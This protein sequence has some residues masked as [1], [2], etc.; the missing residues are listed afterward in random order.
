[1]PVENLTNIVIGSGEGG[2]YLAWH[3]AQSGQ[4]TAVIERRW[5]G[6]SCPNINCLPSKNEIWSAKVANLV[7]H[8]AKF[9]SVTAPG[10]VDMAVVRG[11]K[12]KMVEGLVA[13]H[14][15]R[16]KATGAELIM[17]EAKFAGTNT[18]EVT[19]NGG[20]SRTLRGERIFLNLGTHASI[21]SAP[22]LAACA[23]LTHIEVL[24]LDRLPDHLIVIGGGYVGLEFAQ[25]YRRF[26]SQV[27]VLQHGSQLLAK[28]DPDLAAEILKVFN[29]E[30]IEVLAP[31]K[32]M[33]VEGR[34]GSGVTIK[35][36]TSSGETQISGSDILVATGR[37][38]NTAEIGLDTAGVQVDPRGYI[39]VND[40]L[41]TT[42]TNV[43]AIGECAGSP[44]FTHASLD[45]FRVIRD[46]L[47]GGSRSTRNRVVPSCLFTDPQVAQIG[48]TESEARS[49][50]V[51]YQIAKL[52]MV[53]VLRTRTIDETIGFMKALI[54]PN[55]QRILGFTMI[56]P[57]AGEVMAVV[58]MAMQA[59][60]PYMALRDAI[61]THPTMAEGLN[62]LF[63]NVK[64][65]NIDARA[66]TAV[67]RT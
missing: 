66:A 41:E 42:A 8:S 57:E 31:A 47:A 61:L 39:K 53:A 33:S 56:G 11:R 54:S 64:P 18:L 4:K 21:P 37:V 3:L 55:D 10:P 29:A 28:A 14:L 20:G 32:I 5:I 60:L 35:L 46:N 45:D 43:W 26:G 13:M 16:F 40:R 44:Q 17:G 2:K 22:G 19:V 12:R 6:G 9:G 51:S 65:A 49:Q 24:E 67:P 58:Q 52:P 27:T 63:S 30:G 36:Q 50:G 1:M 62:A 7:Y 59:G 38:P 15:D 48:L 25:A 23:P 34:S